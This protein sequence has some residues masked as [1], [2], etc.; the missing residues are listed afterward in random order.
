MILLC[1]C[2]CL[3]VYL[4]HCTQRRN[5]VLSS[6]LFYAKRRPGMLQL[7]PTRYHAAMAG[8]RRSKPFMR[9]NNMTRYGRSHLMFVHS[10]LE[11]LG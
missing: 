4:L 7:W 10:V 3:C 6:E 5:P 1:V 8:H 9:E 11:C 2:M